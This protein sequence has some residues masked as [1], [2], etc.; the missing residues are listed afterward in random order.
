MAKKQLDL[1]HTLVPLENELRNILQE[2]CQQHGQ[3]SG[4]FDSAIEDFISKYGGSGY[5][6]LDDLLAI[7]ALEATHNSKNETVP[8]DVLLKDLLA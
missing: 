6:S 5:R 8:L 1:S 2:I 3:D 7:S 4:V